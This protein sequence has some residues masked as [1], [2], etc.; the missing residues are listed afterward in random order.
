V[1]LVCAHP[2]VWI[3]RWTRENGLAAIRRAA[4][5]GYDLVIVPMRDLE[6][7]DA[8]AIVRECEKAGIR[9]V[10]SIVHGPESDPTSNDP[11]VAARGEEKLVRAISLARD[12]GATQIGGIP[13]A[14]LV[15][16]SAPVDARGWRQS[17]EI[18]GR[19]AG[20]AARAG[21]RI[22]FEAL[23]RFENSMINTA[24]EACAFA[25]AT[26][27]ANVFVH[28]DS[29]HMMIEEEDPCAAVRMAASRLGFFEFGESHRGALGTG[30]V[31]VRSLARALADAGY[32]GP[33]G[34][35]AFSAN[36]IAAPLAAQL[37]VWRSRYDDPDATAR[38]ARDLIVS[39]L[40]DAGKGVRQRGAP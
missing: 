28:L 6:Q 13:H 9:P 33:V 16:P 3:E 22:T 25:D 40:T 10:A 24:R 30:N 27:A 12:I 29:F 21:I 17:A 14:A 35:E 37:C 32:D 1:N 31:D 5:C 20:V 2:L 11:S 15:R 39:E 34:Y 4:E 23:N 19:A 36:V 26:G 8:P 38:A 18:V 7:I